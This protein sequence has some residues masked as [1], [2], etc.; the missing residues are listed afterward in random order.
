M[1]RLEQIF[2][3]T[4]VFYIKLLLICFCLNI[5]DESWISGVDGQ[6]LEIGLDKIYYL[7]WNLRSDS[8]G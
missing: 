5:A 4:V 7:V 3:L 2:A 8:G 6:G 1:K